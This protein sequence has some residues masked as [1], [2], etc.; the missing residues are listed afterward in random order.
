LDRFSGRSR[1]LLSAAAVR[2][3]ALSGAGL[4]AQ[5]QLDL[6]AALTLQEM[7]LALGRDIQNPQIV[8]TALGRLAHL[9]LFR[10]ELE[11]GDALAAASYTEYC[12]LADG[13]GMAFALST[14]GLIARSQ[15]RAEDAR[16]YLLDS[17]N[18]FREQGDRWGIAHVMLGL[19]HLALHRGDLDEAGQ[20][21]EERLGISREIDNQTGVAHTL[22]L[23]ATLARDR[24]QHMRAAS[25]FE[26]A[27]GIKRRIGDRQATAWALQGMGELALLRGDAR[28][29]Y[30]RLRETCCC[31]VTSM[32]VRG[33]WH[34]SRRLRVSLH[35]S[36]G[37]AA[38]SACMVRQ[39]RSTTPLVQR[40][41]CSTTVGRCCRRRS[42]PPILRWSASSGD[43]AVSS[44]RR[45]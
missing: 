42:R 39:P 20:C 27:L 16:R 24:G 14:R 19:G 1:S 44:A 26:E 17:L 28:E 34:R 33:W 22:D 3:R 6:S 30:A 7:S 9:C 37:L 38:P 32:T 25:H 41:P 8:A 18:L 43:W 40:W 31:V 4:I 29:A 5:Y 11:R 23:L 15:G 12:Q 10:T 35:C 45:R 13:W 2:A 21:W 36:T